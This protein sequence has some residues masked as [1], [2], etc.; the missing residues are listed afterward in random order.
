MKTIYALLRTIKREVRLFAK[1]IKQIKRLD[2]GIK[3]F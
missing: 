3:D 2:N 1:E